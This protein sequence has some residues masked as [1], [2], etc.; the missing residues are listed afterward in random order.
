MDVKVF[1]TIVVRLAYKNP[2]LEAGVNDEWLYARI[3]FND[4]AKRR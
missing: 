1:G 3:Q 2:Q 4:M